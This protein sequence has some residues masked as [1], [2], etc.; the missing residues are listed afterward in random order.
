MSDT[1]LFVILKNGDVKE[2]AEF[3]NAHRGAYLIWDFFCETYFHESA[4]NI[5]ATFPKENDRSKEVWGLWRSPAVP[6]HRRIV[7]ASTFDGIMVKKEDLGKLACA[8]DT[9]AKEMEDPGHLPEQAK[10]IRSLQSR[11]DIIG[12]CWNQTSVNSDVWRKFPVNDDDENDESTR[13][14]NIFKD[15]Y[16]NQCWLFDR[17][18]KRIQRDHQ[19]IHGQ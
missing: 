1:I 13:P 4:S 18:E 11:D 10:V 14:F 6:E 2:Y 17:M 5:M 12:I 3:E 16:R 7:M 8:F 19:G 15:N 9:M